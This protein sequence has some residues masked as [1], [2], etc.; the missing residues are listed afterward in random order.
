[1][2]DGAQLLVDLGATWLRAELRAVD[3]TEIASQRIRSGT[4]G[5]IEESLRGLLLETGIEPRVAVLGVPGRV[6]D[7]AG[8][9]LL[10]YLGDEGHVD[11]R[12]V[13]GDTLEQILVLNDLEAGVRGVE[14]L[15][16]DLLHT[17]QGPREA[18]LRAFVLAMPGTGLGIGLGG[19][20]LEGS[21]SEAGNL[22]A[23]ID[24][25][26]DDEVAAAFAL[27]P[28]KG[29]VS[30]QDFT[31]AGALERIAGALADPASGEAE[32]FLHAVSEAPP[33]R[34][35]HLLLE[36]AP[37]Y[38]GVGRA[39]RVQARFLARAVQGVVL[40]V[41]PDGVFLGGSYLRAAWTRMERPFREALR[42]CT[43]HAAYLGS[44]PVWLA[45]VDDLNLRGLRRAAMTL[46]P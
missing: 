28:E 45:D 46:T 6:L 4:V 34:R 1:M 27:A 2:A 30:Y 42:R 14:T 38:A 29:L 41:L 7:P 8:E 9:A 43:S 36:S 16:P 23:A 37:P 25:R 20:R 13:L 40:T 44:V 18:D 3:G 11:F 39:L 12:Q 32:A 26:D 21:S 24:F 35:P 10:T 17:V 15:T 5:R 31:G 19:P 22:A 33:E